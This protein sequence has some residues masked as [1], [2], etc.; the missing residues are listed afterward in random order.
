MIPTPEQIKKERIGAGL[1][2]TQ[3]GELI[4]AATP[5]KTWNDYE[6]GVQIKQAIWELFLFKLKLKEIGIMMI[7]KSIEIQ[8]TPEQIKKIRKAIKLTQK[9]AAKL[10][11]VSERNWI[12]YEKG[13]INMSIAFWVMFLLKV[14]YQLN[15][16]YKSLLTQ[17]EI[18][19]P[20]PEQISNARKSAGINMAKA[21]S[22][23]GNSRS[24]WKYYEDGKRTMPY[25]KWQ[26]F[27]QRISNIDNN[28]E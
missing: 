24:S 21:A 8:P 4:Y 20:T 3:A 1:S 2:I 9:E 10:L 17:P 18:L 14:Q 16:D 15:I 26:L 11:Y 22:L 12:N 19:P 28:A 25:E 27:Q 13:D 7:D 23:I 6:Q 5:W